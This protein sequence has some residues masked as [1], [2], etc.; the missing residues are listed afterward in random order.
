[1]MDRHHYETF[2]KFGNKSFILHLDNGRGFG[3]HSQDEPSILV[4]LQQCCR[5]RRGTFLR[6]Q[7]LSTESYRLSDAMRESL[8]SDGLAPIL[9]EPHLIALNRRLL[10]IL[11]TAKDC[12]NR[13]GERKVL[14]D[15]LGAW[16]A[17][18]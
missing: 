18:H 2:Q 12:I 3:R 5:I 15:D 14:Q 13:H 4:P 11:E 1:N 9:S 7:L 10:A 17:G 8:Q 16:P 6:L